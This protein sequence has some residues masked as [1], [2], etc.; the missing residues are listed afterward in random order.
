MQECRQLSVKSA[1]WEDNI[2]HRA[3]KPLQG[4]STSALHAKHALWYVGLVLQSGTPV[5]YTTTSVWYGLVRRSGTLEWYTGLVQRYVSLVRSGTS[6]WYALV[7]RSGSPEWYNGLV[8]RCAPAGT[9]D[10][11]PISGT[12]SDSAPECVSAQP[13]RT[14]RIPGVEK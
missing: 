13:D 7:R 10:V 14:S 9:G 8:H 4:H 12:G 1:A 6:V 3:C 11:R 5:W 2:A